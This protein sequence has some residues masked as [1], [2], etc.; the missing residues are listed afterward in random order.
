M[1]PVK[2]NIRTVGSIII[3]H[4][5]IVFIVIFFPNT[6]G[7]SLLSKVYS[8]YLLPGP[9]FSEVSIG[10][11][12]QLS[13]MWKEEGGKWSQPINPTFKSHQ[14]SFSG[15]MNSINRS[16]LDRMIYQ[17]LIVKD[18]AK[19]ILFNDKYKIDLLKTYYKNNYAP[20]GADSIRLIIRHQDSREFEMKEDTLQIIQ[21]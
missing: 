10:D 5:L 11:T 18:S 6:M 1:V 4:F 19:D 16:R 3:L 2:R 13:L 12:Y 9:Y 8:R 20:I 14:A 21:F 7:S 17:Q 15:K